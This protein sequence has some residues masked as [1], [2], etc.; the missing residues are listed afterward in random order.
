MP[1]TAAASSAGGPVSYNASLLGLYGGTRNYKTRD[2]NKLIA[3]LEQN[4][5][6]AAAWASTL[7][8]QTTQIKQYVEKLTPVLLPTDTRVTNHGFVNGVADPIQSVL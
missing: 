1:P 8:I 7:A 4:P 3:F 2:A 5:S 6:K